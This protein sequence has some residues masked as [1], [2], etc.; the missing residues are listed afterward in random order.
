M[1]EALRMQEMYDDDDEEEEE[2]EEEKSEGAKVYLK[3]R[4]DE[5]H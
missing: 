5:Q 1:Q 4:P 2:E 3:L